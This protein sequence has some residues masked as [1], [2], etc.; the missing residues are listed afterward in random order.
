LS[1][2]APKKNYAPVRAGQKENE[3]N[4]LR[5]LCEIHA[6]SGHERP[7]R[8]FL[9]GHIQQAAPRWKTRPELIYGE[10]LQDCLMV[11]MGAPR[12]ALF[13]HMDTVGFTVRYN[14]ELVSIGSPEAEAGA[15]LV[16]HDSV[17]PVAGELAFDADRHA[18]CR[19]GR[20]IDRGTTLTYQPNFTHDRHFIQS[21]GLDNRLGVYSALR[22]AET[23]ENGLLVF[24]CWEEHG[25]GSVGYLADY[26][27]KTFGVRQA[28]ISD[29]TWVSEGVHPGSGVAVSLRDRHIPR[30]HFIDKVLALAKRSKIKFQ[31]EVEGTGSSDGGELQ[32]APVPFDWCFIGAPQQHAHTPHERVHKKDVEAMVALHAYLMQRL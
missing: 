20:P 28:L 27:Y 18:H 32:R 25:G 8:D 29:I 21:P 22:V 19:F 31:L 11:K 10:E 4:L 17:G 3:L 14:N 2:I 13:A 24:S 6:P 26:I 9:I 30:K 16:G 12:T 7:L 5:Q 15:R 23:L 1:R